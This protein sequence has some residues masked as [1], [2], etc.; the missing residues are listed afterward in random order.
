MNNVR[1]LTLPERR[2]FYKTYR[3]DNQLGWYVNQASLN[4]KFNFIW[5]CLLVAFQIGALVCVVVKLNCPSLQIIPTS[6]FTTLA[7]IALSWAQAKR[8]SELSTSYNLTAHEISI[9]SARRF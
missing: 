1:I 9:I 2:D 8:F 6:L 7:G 4:R 3:V 5:F